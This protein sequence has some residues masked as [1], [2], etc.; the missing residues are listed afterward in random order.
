MDHRPHQ[1]LLHRIT[2]NIGL[3]VE[4]TVEQEDPMEDILTPEGPSRVAL[5]LIKTIQTNYKTIW[6]TPASITL[7]ARGIEW[8]YFAPSKGYEFLFCHPISCSL[9]I[10]AVNKKEQQSQQASAPKAKEA[11]RLDLFGR[12]VYSS[13]GLQL[14]IAKQQAILNRHNFNSWTAE[15]KCPSLRIACPRTHSE[16]ATLI[17]EGKTVAKI[18]LQASPRFSRLCSQNHFLG[19]SHVTL[20]VTPGIGPPSRGPEYSPRPS[21]RGFGPF[22]GAKR[23]Q[24]AWP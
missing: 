15:F 2:L 11:K 1:E 8:K 5:P 9:V 19:G 12:K 10:S 23:I 4:E 16:F 21:F 6:Q 14:C 3:Q 17:E 7:M 20:S 22:L 13:G 18:S 24:A